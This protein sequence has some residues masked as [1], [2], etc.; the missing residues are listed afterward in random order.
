MTELQL[1]F[2]AFVIKFQ[3]INARMSYKWLILKSFFIFM[4]VLAKKRKSRHGYMESQLEKK[5]TQMLTA[6]RPFFVLR[7]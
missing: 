6:T 1:P 4:R 7:C 5:I 2:V 3:I